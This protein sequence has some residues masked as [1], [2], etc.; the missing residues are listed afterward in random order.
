MTSLSEQNRQALAAADPAAAERVAAHR[1][2]ADAGIVPARNGRPTLILGGVSFHSRFEPDTEARRW[3]DHLAAGSPEGGI[4]LVFGLGLGYH[5]L[6][7]TEHFAKIDVFEPEPGLIGLAFE[8]LDF[9]GR[10]DRIRFLDTWPPAEE[11]ER[12]LVVAH[13]PTARRH[14]ELFRETDSRPA[15]PAETVSELTG[16]WSGLSGAQDLLAGLDPD[17]RLTDAAWAARAAAPETPLS[18]LAVAI[19]LTTT[20]AGIGEG[21]KETPDDHHP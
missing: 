12:R 17:A 2:P 5:V 13:A 7:L 3:A 8:H 15:A 10:L 14:P 9:S 16:R 19:L 18:P 11:R 21:A 4:P 6:A 20:L 1:P